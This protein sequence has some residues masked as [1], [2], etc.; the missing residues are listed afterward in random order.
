MIW[1]SLDEVPEMDRTFNFQVILGAGLRF[2]RSAGPGI[3][4]EFR[5]HH[6][7]NAGTAGENLGVNAATFLVGLDWILR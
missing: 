3:I 4:L 7:S 6:I 2:R 5:N 1:T